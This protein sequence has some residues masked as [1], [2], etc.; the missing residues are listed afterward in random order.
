MKKLQLNYEIFIQNQADKAD[1]I[2]EST[3]NIRGLLDIISQASN[4]KDEKE[5]KVLRDRLAKLLLPRYKKFKKQGLFQ[6]QFVFADNVTFLRVHKLQKYGDDLSNIRLDFVEANKNKKIIRELFQGKTIHAFRNVYPL[7]DKSG[8]HIGAMEVSYPSEL[9]Q[10]NLNKIS[11]MHTH[12]LVN[13]SMFDSKVWNREDNKVEYLQSIEHK[14]YLLTL[15][16]TH[17]TKMHS[18]ISKQK[19]EGLYDEIENGIAM[20]VPFSL[21]TNTVTKKGYDIVSFYPIYRDI[22]HDIPAWLVTYT[23]APFIYPAI[24]SNNIARVVAFVLLGLLL[25]FIGQVIIQKNR[26]TKILSSYD[27]NVIFSTTDKRGIITHVSK[28]FCRISG[29]KEEELIGQPHSIVRHPDMPKEAFG[30][31]WESIKHDKVWRGEVKN[32]RKDGSYYWVRA[33]IEPLYNDSHK[34]VGYSAIRHDITDK[35]E[36]EELQKEIIFTMGAIGESRSKETGN[37]VKR[38]AEYSKIIALAYGMD[39]KEAEM[40]AEVSPM[41]DIGK[42]AIPDSILNKPAKLTPD[43]RKVIET[44]SKMGY[45]MLSSSNRP[46]MKM[47]SI[48]AHEHHEKYDGTGYPRG[49][50]GEEIHIY[51]RITAIADV[52]DALGSDRIYKKAWNDER[53]FKLFNDESG[54]HFDP[55][56]VDIFFENIDEILEVRDKLRDI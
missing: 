34:F 21:M 35:K 46:L 3:I 33:E 17:N 4:T 49:L 12:F 13:K 43:E 19:L 38:V 5:L 2:Y 37:H 47:A 52:F 8:K 27:D 24:K 14:D 28:E 16:K 55:K 30:D 10:Q 51:G 18:K 7:F 42:I 40:L 48:V 15:S 50:K 36:I 32:K 25:Y 29:Y 23:N 45:E 22:T 56:L 41:H 53:I 20:G 1:V 6:Y 39:T 9:L 44:H 26:L 54:K 11:Q 31:M